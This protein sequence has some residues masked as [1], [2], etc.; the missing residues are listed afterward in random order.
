M[1]KQIPPGV[2][3]RLA[4]TGLGVE[5]RPSAAIAAA[6]HCGHQDGSPRSGL[7]SLAA[8][9]RGL[10]PE[11]WRHPELTQVFGPRGAVYLVAAEDAGVFTK[12]LLPR[13]P[14]RIDVLEN[15]AS[16]IHAALGGRPAPQRELMAALPGVEN[17]RELRWATTLG[18]LQAEWDTV[19]TLVVPV[20]DDGVAREDARLELARRFFRYLGPATARDLR[21][22]LDGSQRDSDA[23]VDA[24]AAELQP[25]DSG[26]RPRFI[27]AAAAAIYAG[28]PPHREV[29][30]LPP[31]DIAISRLHRDEV[32]PDAARSRALWPKAPPPGALLV[33]GAVVGTWRRRARRVLMTPW[34]PIPRRIRNAAEAIVADWPLAGAAGEVRWL[35]DVP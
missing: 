14:A 30:L 18:T 7:L 5:R 15:L 4:V 34:E 17:T 8:R 19:D 31:D 33:D 20:P 1:T 35:D 29:L 16:R 13:D 10:E 24:L 28:P 25:I 22:W 6:A 12:G 21:W 32:V 2:R 11:S 23:T 27:L 9:V 3:Y 26:P